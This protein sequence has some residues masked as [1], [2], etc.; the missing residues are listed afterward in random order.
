MNLIPN[1]THGNAGSLIVGAAVY[2][3]IVVGQSAEP[4][5][6]RTTP[7]ETVVANVVVGTIEAAVT[8]REA[9]ES[10]FVRGL[11]VG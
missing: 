2:I 10:T 6:V 8:A 5:G 1:A 4:S 3:G 7:P 9:C 11:L